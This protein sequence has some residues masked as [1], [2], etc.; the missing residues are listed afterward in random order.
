VARIKVWRLYKLDACD[1]ER[2][3]LAFL[4]CIEKCDVE[5]GDDA[6]LI[7]QTCQS[8]HPNIMFLAPVN[9][10]SWA[11]NWNNLSIELLLSVGSKS[12]QSFTSPY[13]TP[14]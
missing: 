4:A 6:L 13:L 12:L 14:Q 3:G 9:D 1:V 5:D 10:F 8:K 7:I 2:G 11:R